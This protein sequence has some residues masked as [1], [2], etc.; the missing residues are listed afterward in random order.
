MTTI[1]DI[2][3]MIESLSASQIKDIMATVKTNNIRMI[4]TR[5]RE[6]RIAKTELYFSVAPLPF[7]S[8][9]ETYKNHAE[10]IRQQVISGVDL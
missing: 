7:K 6:R 10:G 3:T 5:V 8:D 9:Y 4:D 2:E 1:R